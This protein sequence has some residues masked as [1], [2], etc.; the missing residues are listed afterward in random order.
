MEG[1][2][3]SEEHAASIFRVKTYETKRCHKL[4]DH[5]VEAQNCLIS[6][7]R[8][9]VVEVFA[10]LGYYA[11][12]EVSNDVHRR[13]KNSNFRPVCA[14]LLTPFADSQLTFTVY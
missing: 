14:V 7:F 1:T 10:L 13:A 9:G 2:T 5:N 6:R 12:L 11:A 4:E 3:I 8:H